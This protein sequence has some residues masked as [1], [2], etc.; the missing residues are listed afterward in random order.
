MI[1]IL[2]NA[3]PV[4]TQVAMSI[5]RRWRSGTFLHR[6]ASPKQIANA[7]MSDKGTIRKAS[8]FARCNW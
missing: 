7:A 1:G 5:S 8:L 6:I 4:S 3:A 2:P